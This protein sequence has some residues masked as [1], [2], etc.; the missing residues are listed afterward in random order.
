[1]AIIAAAISAPLGAVGLGPLA[2]DNLIDGPLCGFSLT[3]ANPYEEATDFRVY[4]VGADDEMPQLRVTILPASTRLGPGKSR[5]LLVIASDLT[6]GENYNFRV[7][8]ERAALPE[9]MRINARVC[10]KLSARRTL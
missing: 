10:S 9:G 4:A 7:C 8:A 6:T 1:M 5:R 3:I 2:Q